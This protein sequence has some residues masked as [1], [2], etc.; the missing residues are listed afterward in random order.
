M[1]LKWSISLGGNL[2]FLDFLRKKFYNINYREI[3]IFSRRNTL[4]KLHFFFLISKRKKTTILRDRE[5]L[6][7]FR[8]TVLVCALNV[9]ALNES[10]QV[11]AWTF[12][13]SHHKKMRKTKDSGKL[14][15]LMI[16]LICSCRSNFI[17]FE[18]RDEKRRSVNRFGKILP[19]WQKFTSLA[20]F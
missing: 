19:L 6:A 15:Q 9:K 17:I 4:K 8:E 12:D 20:N 1:L 7:S 10:D 18:K 5:S 11:A 13:R 14:Q 3:S 16:L 2:D